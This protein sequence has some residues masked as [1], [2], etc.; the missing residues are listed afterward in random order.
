MWQ[1]CYVGYEEKQKWQ[2]KTLEW[3]IPGQTLGAVD[4]K[5]PEAQHSATQTTSPQ[6]SSLI[7]K[8]SHNTK[9]FLNNYFIYYEKVSK[10][11][12]GM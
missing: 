10:A 8:P 3:F 6:F 11:I 4:F 2:L 7:R 9:Q 12:K 1:L 5:G